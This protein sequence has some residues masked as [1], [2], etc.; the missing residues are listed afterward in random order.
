MLKQKRYQITTDAGRVFY[1]WAC[2]KLGASR[3]FLR[4]VAVKGPLCID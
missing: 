2:T 1:V 3:K 4:A